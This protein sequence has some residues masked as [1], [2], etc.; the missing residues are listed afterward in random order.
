VS[1][2]QVEQASSGATDTLEWAD[3][4]G[5]TD[6]GLEHSLIDAEVV[7][8]ARARGLR[9]GAW[10]VNEE[11]DLRRLAALGVDVITTDRPDLALRV[12]DALR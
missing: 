11:S 10:T 4:S 2:R 7:A 8:G 6:L 12:R 1:R 3:R 5:V 9:L